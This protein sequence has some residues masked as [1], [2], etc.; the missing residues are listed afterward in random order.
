M[1]ILLLVNNWLGWQVTEW[2][3]L[4][5]A[6]VAALVLHP[7][8][9]RK[10]GDEIERAAA[11][12]ADRIVGADRLHERETLDRIAALGADIALSVLFGYILKA[13]FLELF[14]SGVINLH[15]AY[16]PFNR[17][18][19]PD[20]WSIVE[21]TP[22]GVTI[23][24]VD[25]GVDTGEVLAQ[26]EVPVRTSDTGETLYRRLEREGLDLFTQTW[27]R[28]AAGAVEG[29]PQRDGGTYHRTRDVDAIDEIDLDRE[30]T[31]RHLL[32]V[33]RARTFPPYPGAYFRDGDRRVYVRLQLIPENDGEASA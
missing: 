27:P 13:P 16:L 20:V 32:N 4:D 8:H 12:P 6:E 10:F 19:H 23:H 7:E 11:L 15:P 33:L 24:R 30:Y 28:I 22:A 29:Q 31:A 17:G 9:R 3:R 14:P 21:G 25:V 26:R 2:L 1:R 18:A 5:G